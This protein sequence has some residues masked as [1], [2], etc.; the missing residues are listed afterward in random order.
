M[1]TNSLRKRLTLS[2][3]KTR[4]LIVFVYFWTL[5]AGFAQEPTPTPTPEPSATPAA[6]M[7]DL[8][9]AQTMTN[10]LTCLVIG[11]LLFI[12]FMQRARL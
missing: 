6:T 7:N 8:L 11:V 1:D 10:Q 5:I 12:G 2:D 3:N 4:A 9:D